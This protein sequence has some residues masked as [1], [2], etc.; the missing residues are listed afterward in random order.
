MTANA[1]A[2]CAT[3]KMWEIFEPT[4][5]TREYLVKEGYINK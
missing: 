1:L 3:G 4:P 5:L 2:A